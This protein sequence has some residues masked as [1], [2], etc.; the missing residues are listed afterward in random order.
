MSRHV[1][2]ALAFVLLVATVRAP[3]DFEFRQVARTGQTIPGLTSPV[4]TFGHWVSINDTGQVAFKAKLADNSEA[5]VCATPNASGQYDPNDPNAWRIVDTGDGSTRQFSDYVGINAN[6]AVSYRLRWTYPTVHF[7]IFR[8]S[9]SVAGTGSPLHFTSLMPATDISTEGAGMVSFNGAVQDGTHVYWQIRKGD[10]STG[11]QVADTI[12]IAAQPGFTSLGQYTSINETGL[13]AFTGSHPTLGTGVFAGDETTITPIATT[14]MGFSATGARPSINDADLVAFYG[15]GPAGEGIYIGDQLVVALGGIVTSIDAAVRVGLNDNDGVAFI[16]T[17][18]GGSVSALFRRQTAETEVVVKVGDAPNGAAPIATIDFWD[19]LNND[20]QVAFWAHHDDPNVPFDALWVTK[21]TPS[22]GQVV[23]ADINRTPITGAEVY[24]YEI[25]SDHTIQPILPPSLTDSNGHFD[26]PQAFTD[27]QYQGHWLGLLAK[28]GYYDPGTDLGYFIVNYPN[29]DPFPAPGR[30]KGTETI[31]FPLP[32]VLQ[33]GLGGGVDAHTWDVLCEYLQCDSASNC[34]VHTKHQNAP[35]LPSFMTFVMPSNDTQPVWGYLDGLPLSHIPHDTNI[36]RLNYFVTNQVR[37]ALTDIVADLQMR[38]R[39]PMHL[40]AH[41]M[42]GTITRGWMYDKRP[43]VHRYVSFDGVQGGTTSYANLGKWV[44]GFAEWYMNGINAADNAFP[45][46]NDSSSCRWNYAHALPGTNANYLLISASEDG[47]VNPNCSALGVG[48]TIREAWSVEPNGH[49]Y[50][51]IGGVEWHTDASH[52]DTHDRADIVYQAA[53]FLAC[54]AWPQ[55]AYPSGS[56]YEC[57]DEPAPLRQESIPG[58]HWADTLAEAQQVV[59]SSVHADYNDSID[60]IVMIE[61]LGGSFDLLD[62]SGASLIPADPQVVDFGGGRSIAFSIAT[63][64]VGTYTV[65]LAAAEDRLTGYVILTFQ[66]GRRLVLE[67]PTEPMLPSASTT[68]RASVQDDA[69]SVIVGTGGTM[70][71][72][73]AIPD[74]SEETLQLFDDGAHG[75]GEA[76]DGVFANEFSNTSLGGRYLVEAHGIIPVD[77]EVVERSAAGMFVVNSSPAT[78]IAVT[79]ER[80]VDDDGDG[81]YERLEFDIA[82]STN[83]PGIYQVRAVLVDAAQAV[84]AEDHAVFEIPPGT[85]AH[86]ATLQVDAAAIIVHGVSG[87]WT[88]AEIELLDDDQVIRVSTLPDWPT[89]VYLLSAFAPPPPPV[90]TEVLPDYGS[91]RG[92]DQVILQGGYLEYVS[93]ITWGGNP[94]AEF[95]VWSE[96][97]IRLYTPPATDCAGSGA[98]IVLTTAWTAATLSDAFTYLPAPGDMNLDCDADLADFAGFQHCFA[99]PDVTPT[100]ECA[101][102][103]IDQDDDVDWDDF[104]VITLTGPN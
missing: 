47:V 85:P 6:G 40:C 20:I 74:Q 87:P 19:G 31:R 86:T 88:L 9:T 53:C 49:K 62:P 17:T 81:L 84:I 94:V 92:G 29:N 103:D 50:R 43:P 45:D 77:G 102:G 63:P 90:V 28:V 65:R 76:G 82:A 23:F 55:G 35:K 56:A 78:L 69:G 58:V 71:V 46:V 95:D 41:S 101:A 13:V 15:I 26:R 44:R 32:V 21:G 18:D 12:L 33:A 24:A 96:S 51:F 34:G 3:A 36:S 99:G 68:V 39:L 80:P 7:W 27:P 14:T 89:A 104:S 79:A 61:G 70:E 98:P 83:E 75:D 25:T 67:L 48:R 60:V 30:I 22:P 100:S 4:A 52:S 72:T 8:D 91:V 16:G 42:G 93:A 54:G 59:E 2:L 64:P 73:I 1:A 11:N 5:V 10:G 97:A 37:P 38:A 66:N 57:V